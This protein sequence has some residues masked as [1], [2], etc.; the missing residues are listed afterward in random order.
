MAITDIATLGLQV[1]S[2]DV[3][4]AES[5]LNQL[6]QAGAKAEQ[7]TKRLETATDRMNREV[8]EARSQWQRLRGVIGPIVG[9]L[10]SL[11]VALGVAELVRAVDLYK[12]MENRLRLVTDSTVEL[13][14]TQEELFQ[15][16][17]AS[18]VVFNG[19]VDLYARLA[20]STQDL[21][22]SNR[23]LLAVTESINQT[24]A[25]S[26]TNAQTAAGALFQL[27]QGLAAG[28]LRGEELNAVLEGIPRLAEAIARGMG[29]TIGELRALGAEGRITSE[30]IID[31]LLARADII[32]E[33]FDKMTPT[34]SQAFTVL[35]NSALRAT[36]EMDTMLGA[37]D[38]VASAIL[39][40]ANNFEIVEAAAAG[41]ATVVSLLALRLLPSL[42]VAIEAFTVAIAANP[43][44]LLLVGLSSAVAA[45][46]LY[47]D[48]MVKVRGVTV[49]VLEIVGGAFDLAGDTITEAV[50][51]VV[52]AFEAAQRG[53][54][55]LLGPGTAAR[56][57]D[58][59][60]DMTLA[61][62]ALPKNV[63]N[64]VFGT[65]KTITDT[66]IIA[67]EEVF[68]SGQQFVEQLSALFEKLG[69]AVQR[70]ADLDFTGARQA[71]D[72]ARRQDVGFGETEILTRVRDQALTNL[73]TDFVGDFIDR[74]VDAGEIAVSDIITAVEDRALERSRQRRLGDVL[75]RRE[76]LP[77]PLGAGPQTEPKISQDTQDRI[78]ELGRER[79]ELERLVAARRISTEAF[80]AE[81][82]AIEAENEAYD[83]GLTPKQRAFD[84]VVSLVRANQDLQNAIDVE[85]TVA[86]IRLETAE[87]ERLI[88]ARRVSEE[89]YDAEKAAIDAENEARKLGLTP[90]DEEYELVVRLATALGEL[91][92][93]LD[94]VAE[95]E[96]DHN[97][98]VKEINDRL[99]D[100]FPTYE[101]LKAEAD[102]W[103]AEQLTNL[104]ATKAGY[105]EFVLD[106]ETIYV[107]MLK[108]A[109]RKDLENSKVWS[110]GVQ[111]ALLDYAET[112]GDAAAQWEQ[113]TTTA[114]G[115][116]ED[117]FVEWART[118][119]FEAKEMVDVILAELA[120]L[121]VRQAIVAPLADAIGL[122]LHSGGLVGSGGAARSVPLQA[123]AAAQRYHAGGVAGLGPNEV[124][125]IAE[126][127]EEVI[128]RSDPR[129]R[130]NGGAAMGFS[131]VNNI[132]INVGGTTGG[133]AGNEQ[134]QAELAETLG[135]LVERSIDARMTEWM[136]QQMR[137]G[138]MLNRNGAQNFGI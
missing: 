8:A 82:R 15:I 70:A 50:D 27:G 83:L 124:P 127:G 11:G 128:T 123:I 3:P 99:R 7:Q 121:A 105:E 109:R 100:I 12:E 75:A 106:I 134:S 33:E 54:D 29:V 84:L 40:L 101:N 2:R 41:V 66:F 118:G 113:F 44:G 62:L 119:K 32:Q 112:A 103:R 56:A 48:E 14:M 67:F 13:V 23:S 58:F 26:G 20:R 71:I 85:A 39:V 129:H 5:E 122:T 74:L 72:A 18:R 94:A 77:S 10:A 19:T 61:L 130:F 125:V 24:I 63:I 59:V 90:K 93:E 95:A 132:S 91:K 28:A 78:S 4:R 55:D 76:P 64:I 36:G 89:T 16:A 53:I 116:M 97:E 137:P 114:L 47:R 73:T 17:Q 51:T 87:I 65:A 35:S 107:E 79:Q 45:L 1:E 133:A 96:R 111:R 57:V 38:A 115:R 30:T 135:V 60:E 131:M 88:A 31:A 9:L 102:E 86:G 37:S 69:E 43:L 49:S 52:A 126:R 110:D 117:A 22:V 120:R 68:E 80:E 92:N 81:T 136:R 46:V 42:V 98:A 34:I 108:E 138:N 6:T 21:G 104:D 25:I